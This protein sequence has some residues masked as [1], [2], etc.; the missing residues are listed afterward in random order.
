MAKITEDAK[1]LLDAIRAFV[2]IHGYAP[3]VRELAEEL[4][5]G[6]STVTKGLNELINFDKIR[7]AAGVARGIVVREE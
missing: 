6:H 5:V 4:G 7:R 1:D 2:Q 3:T